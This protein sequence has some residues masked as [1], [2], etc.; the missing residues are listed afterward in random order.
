MTFPQAFAAKA[1][2]LFASGSANETLVCFYVSVANRPL[3]LVPLG[4]KSGREAAP[5]R[6]AT[7]GLNRCISGVS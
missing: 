4:V 2:D 1:K 5:F 6:G 3:P 7:G